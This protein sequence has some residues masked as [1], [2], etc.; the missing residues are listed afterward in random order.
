MRKNLEFGG[1]GGREKT[2]NQPSKYYVLLYS[3]SRYSSV[4]VRHDKNILWQSTE[5]CY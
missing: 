3:F 1:V 5:Q 4:K 2:V